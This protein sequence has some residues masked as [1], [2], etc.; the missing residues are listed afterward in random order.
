M[1][2]ERLE[3]QTEFDVTNADVARVIRFM[4]EEFD[5][6]N[7]AVVASAVAA[8]TLFEIVFADVANKA[9]LAAQLDPA[10]ARL[11]AVMLAEFE[12]HVDTPA[13][14]SPACN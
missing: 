5:N 2:K 13:R 12:E 11:T 10:I 6:P 8:R 7:V 3:V 1:T 14:S 9:D 4:T